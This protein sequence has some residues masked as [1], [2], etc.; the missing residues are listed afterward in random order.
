MTD[1]PRICDRPTVD[2]KV[3]GHFLGGAAKPGIVKT[4]YGTQRNPSRRL[5]QPG[6]ESEL[7]GVPEKFRISLHCIRLASESSTISC[8]RGW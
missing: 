5:L 7:L 6:W 4:L 1:H 2:T 8:N 3:D